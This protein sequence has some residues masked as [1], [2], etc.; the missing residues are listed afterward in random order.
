VIGTNVAGGCEK[1]PGVLAT[2]IAKVFDYNVTRVGLSELQAREAGYEVTT[3]LVPGYEHATYY[4]NGKEIIVK[5]VAEKSSNRL[6]GGQ[7]VG[8]GE[9]AKRIDVR[10]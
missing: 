8:P 1:F 3:C 10:R 2:A 9:A 7:V 4:P 6:L 5:L